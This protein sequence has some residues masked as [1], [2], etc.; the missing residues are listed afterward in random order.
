ML[1]ENF[2]KRSQWGRHNGLT[3]P[4]IELSLSWTYAFLALLN[5]IR[6]EITLSNAS[7]FLHTHGETS[8]IQVNLVVNM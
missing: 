7:I 2:R 3:L 8:G 6:S 4:Y 5:K 1:T